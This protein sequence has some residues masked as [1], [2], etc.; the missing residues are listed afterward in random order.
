M[1]DVDVLL[2]FWLFGDVELVIKLLKISFLKSYADAVYVL[3]AEL[4]ELKEC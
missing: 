3:N 4:C 2:E 1:V